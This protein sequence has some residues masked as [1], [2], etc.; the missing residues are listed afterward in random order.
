MTR[1]SNIAVAACLP[2]LAGVIAVFVRRVV[3]LPAPAT[4]Y[5]VIFLG[6]AGGALFLRR[7]FVRAYL[8]LPALLIYAPLAAAIAWFVGIFFGC[9]LFHECR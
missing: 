9:G 2:A 6:I 1:A 8:R 4:E 7:L 5:L 3:T